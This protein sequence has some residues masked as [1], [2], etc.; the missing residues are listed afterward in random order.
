MNEIIKKVLVMM[1]VVVFLVL[2][3]FM[4]V[5]ILIINS[6]KP[7]SWGHKHIFCENKVGNTWASYDEANLTITCSGGEKFTYPIKENGNKNK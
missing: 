2:F 3:A 4:S 5:N 6:D 1:S 7:L